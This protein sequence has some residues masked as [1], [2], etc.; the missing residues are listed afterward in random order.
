[1]HTIRSH[2]WQGDRVSSQA[3][4]VM[5]LREKAAQMY[6]LQRCA[7]KVAVGGQV[8]IQIESLSR[9]NTLLLLLAGIRPSRVQ[10]HRT[11]LHILIR[12]CARVE[13]APGLRLM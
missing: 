9:M 8:Q 2:S 7:H 10:Y 13:S 12:L 5:H 4:T 6:S 11:M 3:F 1:M